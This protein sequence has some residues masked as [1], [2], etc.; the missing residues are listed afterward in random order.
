MRDLDAE[1]TKLCE[2]VKLD[3]G[4]IDT[5]NK[6]KSY[7]SIDEQKIVLN[8]VKGVYQG[9]KGLLLNYA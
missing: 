1:I 3:I 5:I 9:M 7:M 4:V 6:N 8:S 2:G